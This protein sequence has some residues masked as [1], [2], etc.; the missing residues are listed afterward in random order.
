MNNL[1]KLVPPLLSEE[2][3]SC[4][5]TTQAL[6]GGNLDKPSPFLG[7]SMMNVI[8]QRWAVQRG[9]CQPRADLN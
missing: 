4:M 6:L 1:S 3:L 8:P 5:D 7:D 9:S 2:A